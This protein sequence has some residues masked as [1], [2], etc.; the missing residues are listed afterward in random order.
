MTA[1]VMLRNR[2]I[3]TNSAAK[4]TIM[5]RPGQ[6]RASIARITNTQRMVMAATG[7]MTRAKITKAMGTTMPVRLNPTAG[8]TTASNSVMFTSTTA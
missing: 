7:I 5:Q 4:D 3:P 8:S 1:I 6:I 2:A